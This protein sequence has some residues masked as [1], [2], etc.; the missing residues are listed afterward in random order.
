MEIEKESLKTSKYVVAYIDFLGVKRMIEED[1][2]GSLLVQFWVLCSAAIE[3]CKK[4]CGDDTDNTVEVKMFSDNVIFCKKVIGDN[5]KDEVK[6]IAHIS[7]TASYFQYFAFDY[8][9]LLVRGGIS[10]GQLYIDPLMV[11]GQA[12]LNAYNIEN[13]IALYPRIVFDPY[14]ASSDIGK[15]VINRR[16]FIKDSDGLYYVDYL[17]DAWS[18]LN[19]KDRQKNYD[20]I[21]VLNMSEL[22]KYKNDISIFQK[23]KW[24][25][26]Y[27]SSAYLRN[28]IDNTLKKDNGIT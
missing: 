27:M 8:L 21:L 26:T 22:F 9:G 14:Y 2:D 6:A 13:K 20:D 28:M 17:T 25:E 7:V 23:R 11:W 5:S 10:I 3:R 1:Q 4:I 15:V 18:T 24:Q 16:P 12:L 19:Q